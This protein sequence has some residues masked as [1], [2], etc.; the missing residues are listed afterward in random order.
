MKTNIL[1][2]PFRKFGLTIRGFLASLVLSL[3]VFISSPAYSQS[4]DETP[5]STEFKDVSELLD[6]SQDDLAAFGK[7]AKHKVEELTINIAVI[8]DNGKSKTMRNIGVESALKLFVDPDK[9]IM[10]TSYRYK[11]VWRIKKRTIREYLKRLRI[12]SKTKVVINNYDMVYVSDFEKAPDGKY[13]ATATFF[14]MYSA[15]SGDRL[16]YR[17]KTEKTVEIILELIEDEVYGE[18]R[19]IVRLGDV[20]VKETKII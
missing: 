2:S 17:D 5:D 4:N 19:W 15:Y 9:N 11:G 13:H 1:R 7:Q 3:V 14:Q 6:L 20:K 16:R 12:I 8:A 18:K 10:E